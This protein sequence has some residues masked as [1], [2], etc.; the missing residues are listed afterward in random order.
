MVKSRAIKIDGKVRTEK[1]Y[2]TGFMGACRVN[3]CALCL[4][5]PHICRRDRH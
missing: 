4:A 1:C 3:A 5:E 2:P